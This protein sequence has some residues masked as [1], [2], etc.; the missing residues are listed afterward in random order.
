MLPFIFHYKDTYIPTFFF[1]VM[2]GSLAATFYAYWQAGKKNLSQVAILD[3]GMVGTLAGIMG[4]RLFHVFVEAPDYYWADPI[5]VFYFWQGGFVGYG[6]FFGILIGATVYLKI[7]KLPILQYWDLLALGCPLI[8]LAVRLGCLGAGCCYGKPTDFFFHLTF[9]NPA[10]DAGHDF[11]GIHLHATQVYDI[12]NALFDFTVLYIV[13]KRK[14]FHGQITLLFLMIYAFNRFL[15]EFL[16]G[17]ADRGVY[18]DGSISTSQITGLII[19]AV[20]SLAYWKLS[21]NKIRANA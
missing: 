13:D 21:K 1:M 20:G 11:P 6:A 5:R 18:L 19:L 8:I 12:I 14:Q 7:R 15:I 10:S 3:I 2:V 9:T 16:R 17:D 4:A